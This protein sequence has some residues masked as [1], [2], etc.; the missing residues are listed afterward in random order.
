MFLVMLHDLCVAYV[1]T[2]LEW[3]YPSGYVSNEKILLKPIYLLNSFLYDLWF[4]QFD[5]S[6]S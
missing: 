4:T 3:Q 2:E 5:G 6:F 1:A